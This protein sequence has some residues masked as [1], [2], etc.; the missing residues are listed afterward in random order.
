MTFH[1][2]LNKAFQVPAFTATHHSN[3]RGGDPLRTF[4]KRVEII[5]RVHLHVK[6]LSSILYLMVLH[7]PQSHCSMLLNIYLPYHNEFR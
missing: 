2:R 3:L 4:E 6:I 1:S 7:F 5:Q